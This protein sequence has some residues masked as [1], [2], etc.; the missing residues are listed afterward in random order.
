MVVVKRKLLKTKKNGGLLLYSEMGM[1][2]EKCERYGLGSNKQEDIL[3][4]FMNAQML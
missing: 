4:V 1:E 3:C 2:K